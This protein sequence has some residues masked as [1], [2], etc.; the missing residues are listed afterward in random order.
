MMEEET[1]SAEQPGYPTE[2]APVGDYE[3]G[4]GKP[5]RHS[6]FK[7]G[8]SG[9]PNGRLK[10]SPVE[11]LRPLL[12]SILAEPVTVRENG[13]TRTMTT[14]ESML[15]IQMANAL[16]GSKPAVRALIRHARKAGLFT[17]SDPYDSVGGVVETP[18]TGAA[19]KILRVYRA[20]K[21]A[22]ATPAARKEAE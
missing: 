3:V 12:D 14:L 8:Q 19:G 21:A 7:K 13:R 11:D 5:P 1:S 17:R 9:N 10:R 20:E 22:R 18:L 2:S 4:Y 6:Q 15:Q 16:N